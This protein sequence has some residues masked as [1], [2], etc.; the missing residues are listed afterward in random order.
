MKHLPS[1]DHFAVNDLPK[2]TGRKVIAEW[3]D[4]AGRLS[5]LSA[6]HAYTA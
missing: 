6:E 5:S 1:Y 4:V 2:D 3:R